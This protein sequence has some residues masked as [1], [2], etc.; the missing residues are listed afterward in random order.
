MVAVSARGKQ[1]VVHARTNR[2]ARKAASK[3]AAWHGEHVPAGVVRV[4]ER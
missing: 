4:M 2:G 1:M 3:K